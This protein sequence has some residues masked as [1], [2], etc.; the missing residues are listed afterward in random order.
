MNIQR[1][2]KTAMAANSFITRAGLRGVFHIEPTNSP[3]C[4]IIYAKDQPPCPRWEPNAEDLAADDWEVT[5]GELI[6]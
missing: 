1:A 4:C 6:E 5:K 3:D 2:I